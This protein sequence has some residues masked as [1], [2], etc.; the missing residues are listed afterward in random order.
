MQLSG[1]AFSQSS[2]KVLSIDSIPSTNEYVITIRKGLKQFVV[3]SS[4]CLYKQPTENS[5]LLTKGMKLSLT[6]RK[7][8][9]ENTPFFELFSNLRNG[10]NAVYIDGKKYDPRT[11]YFYSE[12][13]TG[14]W[15]SE[16]C[17]ADSS[18]STD[19]VE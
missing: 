17:K 16:Y 12:C 6:L 9:E 18:K 19:Q 4:Y 13:I 3:L 7:M 8:N 5:V 14:L 11:K 2:Y 10:S 15:Y 1:D